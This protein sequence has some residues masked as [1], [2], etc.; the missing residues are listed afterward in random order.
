MVDINISPSVEAHK[1]AEHLQHDAYGD[2]M[3]AF[4]CL[5][6]GLA[7]LAILYLLKGSYLGFVFLIMF[8]FL[9][10]GYAYYRASHPT[11]V[12]DRTPNRNIQMWA[13]IASEVVFFGAIIGISQLVKIRELLLGHVFYNTS[14]IQEDIPITAIN[15]FILILSSL[16]MILAQQAI[17]KGENEKFKRFLSITFLLGAIFISIQIIEYF[18]LVSVDGFVPSKGLYE[19][20]FFLQ[21]GFHGFH[22]TI[23]LIALLGMNI[24]AY[25]NK[26]T[27]DNRLAVELMA[28][29]WHFIDLAWI[30]I[31]TFVYLLNIPLV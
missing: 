15:T 5:C 22:V 3:L 9:V 2:K 23:G 1:G 11:P 25:F 20:T 6:S 14:V 28:L 10:I 29:Y 8:L 7:L 27:K 18:L 26:F 16:T 30:V 21:T 12:L 4:L 19:A 24:G 31:F 17:A 13:F